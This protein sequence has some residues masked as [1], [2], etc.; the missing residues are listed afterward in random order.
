V[1]QKDRI[2]SSLVSPYPALA[3]EPEIKNFFTVTV[4]VV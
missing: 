1:G 2:I 3:L 4:P